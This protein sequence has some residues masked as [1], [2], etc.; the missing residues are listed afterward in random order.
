[1][2]ALSARPW[3][4]VI[5]VLLAACA[6]AAPASPGKPAPTAA[7]TQAQAAPAA[8]KPP[9]G[10]TTAPAAQSAAT[11]VAPLSPPVALKVGS[12]LTLGE[13]PLYGATE[14]GYFGAEG[15]SVELVPFDSGANM[16][17]PLA[18]GELGGGGGAM[19]AGLC[20]AHARGV[21]F[22]IVSGAGVLGTGHVPPVWMVRKDLADS[23]QI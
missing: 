2:K 20:H 1:M 17:G 18:G 8:A 5:L 16:I 9:A 7:P 6:P 21:G 23:S 15:R 4:G 12:T 10:A 22:V 14:E 3:L 11:A 13:T 19:S